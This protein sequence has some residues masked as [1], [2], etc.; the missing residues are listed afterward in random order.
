[1]LVPGGE[2][3]S[4]I[5]ELGAT[6]VARGD[7]DVGRG[8][9]GALELLEHRRAARTVERGATVRGAQPGEAGRR[10]AHDGQEQDGRRD[11][12]HARQ[13]T[14]RRGADLSGDCEESPKN[15]SMSSRLYDVSLADEAFTESVAPSPPTYGCCRRRGA[16][17]RCAVLPLRRLVKRWT[18]PSDRCTAARGVGSNASPR[19]T[20]IRPH[21]PRSKASAGVRSARSRQGNRGD[22]DGRNPHPP[23]RVAGPSAFRRAGKPANVAVQHCDERLPCTCPQ[24]EPGGTDRN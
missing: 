9:R 5:E 15:V 11:S 19:N 2:R 3:Q 21:C 17:E 18:R 13:T 23:S 22:H 8:G 10:Q 20:A 6:R 24:G 16:Q 7:I 14:G 1:M 12:H 4:R